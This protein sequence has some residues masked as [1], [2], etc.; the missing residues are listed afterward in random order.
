MKHKLKNK[1]INQIIT[2]IFET[3][4]AIGLTVASDAI[5][6]KYYYGATKRYLSK[7]NRLY[8]PF[9]AWKCL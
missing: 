3:I 8:S 9:I 6:K 1:T 5:Q 4:W 2:S 7:V